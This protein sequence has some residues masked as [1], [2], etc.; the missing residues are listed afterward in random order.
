MS[1]LDRQIEQLRRCEIIKEHEVRALCAKAR[2]ILIEESNVQQVDSPVT[3][4]HTVGWRSGMLKM[5]FFLPQEIHCH[6]LSPREHSLYYI[7]KMGKIE[8]TQHI[9][10]IV[11]IHAGHNN[12][13][14]KQKHILK[15]NKLNTSLSRMHIN[16]FVCNR[17][18][19]TFMVNSMTSRSSL[20]LEESALKPIICSWGTL[21]I[22]DFTVLRLS[23]CCW[24]SR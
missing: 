21:W 6:M 13:Q 17:F 7:F 12:K 19:E 18:V 22:V 3:V 10:I 5:L 11:I 15:I 1:D 23:S 9:Y 4:C 16:N 24:H 2:E 8:I 20:K 14:H